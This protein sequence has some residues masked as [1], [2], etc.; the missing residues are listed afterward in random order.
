MACTDYRWIVYELTGE[1]LPVASGSAPDEQSASRE[2]LHYAMQY[3]QDGPVKYRLGH[4]RKTL[5]E[6]E[7]RGVRID[8]QH[9]AGHM[10]GRDAA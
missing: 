1:C 2:M 3:G 5:V 6:G 7:L 4:G 10:Q 9:G 8:R